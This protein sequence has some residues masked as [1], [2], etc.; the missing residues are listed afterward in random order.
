MHLKPSKTASYFNRSQF[1]AHPGVRDLMNF[2]RE[3][4]HFILTDRVI[5]T[6][7]AGAQDTEMCGI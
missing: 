1:R 4:P 2:N 6:L 7:L 5:P 3:V